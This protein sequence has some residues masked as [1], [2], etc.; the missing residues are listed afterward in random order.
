MVAVTASPTAS[1]ADLPAAVPNVA[2]AAGVAA[3]AFAVVASFADT[4]IAPVPAT[5]SVL[6]PEP[7]GAGTTAT[8]V[9]LLS[10]AARR[11]QENAARTGLPRRPRVAT[12]RLAEAEAPFAPTGKFVPAPSRAA[13]AHRP[14]PAKRGRRL[15]A[16][17]VTIAAMAFVS[18]MFVS[19]SIPAEA[20]LSAS[21]VEAAVLEAQRPTDT[22]PSQSIDL[23]G[24]DTITIERDGYE[25]STI[26]AV[27]AASGIR[28][29]ATFTNNPNG[30]IQWPFA[31]GVHIGDEFGPRNCA[32]CSANHGGQD[33]NPGLGAPIQ[34][35]SDGVVSFAEDGENSLGVHMIIDHMI[36][37]ELVSSVYA[38]MI[39][40]SMLFSAGD[41]V[42]AGQV[43]GK[44]GSTGMSTGPHLHF[45]IREGGRS[46]TKVPPL[47]WLYAHVN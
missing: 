8:E 25:S 18:L 31:V 13:S 29:E 47:P 19:T 35:I 22:E 38:H 1:P 26:A 30:T 33:F 41:V 4:A 7:A 10:R 9:P 39:H 15:A 34:S 21:D 14:T 27:A 45:E 2:E 12:A 24:G 17:S 3:A 23:A 6:N 20:L 11:A 36:D 43:I 37:G 5:V 28:M 32:G 42:K 44:T 40:G 46:G 16:T